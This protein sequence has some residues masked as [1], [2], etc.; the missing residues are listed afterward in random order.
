MAYVIT[1]GCIECGRCM[2]ECP[3]EAIYKG[4]GTSVIDPNKCI[5]C[6]ICRGRMSSGTD[7]S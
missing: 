1:K 3:E 6:G 7:R 5:D 2:R 4:T